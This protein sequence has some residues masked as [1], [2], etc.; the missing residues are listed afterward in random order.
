MATENE[1]ADNISSSGVS[2]TRYKTHLCQQGNSTAGYINL[3]ASLCVTPEDEPSENEDIPGINC[4]QEEGN[5]NTEPQGLLLGDNQ[6]ADDI[7][8]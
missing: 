5:L 1:H 6:H 3:S 8:G 7:C 4:D 2:K